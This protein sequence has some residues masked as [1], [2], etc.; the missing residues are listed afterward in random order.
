MRENEL[1]QKLR[2]RPGIGLARKACVITGQPPS[3]FVET[4]KKKSARKIDQAASRSR[5]KLVDHCP[6]RNLVACRYA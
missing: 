6:P 4:S 2:R 1:Q 5:E 3:Y